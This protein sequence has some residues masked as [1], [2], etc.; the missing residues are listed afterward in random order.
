MFS[1]QALFGKGDKFL[2]LLEEAAN[3][4][5]ESVQRAIQLL[6]QPV[7]SRNL[8]ALVVARRK[9]KRIAEQ[10]SEELVRTFVTGLERE[11]IEAL[12]SALYRIPKSAEKF[13]EHLILAAPQLDGVDLSRQADLMGRATETVLL[14]VRQLR[15]MEQLEKIKDLNTR[16]QYLEGEADKVML[17][18]LRD[19]YSGKYDALRAMVIRD[20]YELMEKNIDRS[21]DVGN[22]IVHIVLKNS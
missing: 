20:L 12:A 7:Q 17:E 11:D 3:E 16:L 13:A 5:H 8:D 10:I 22:I 1:L 21:R 15:N 9:E 4:G 2:G 14:M 19:L 18:L 6:K